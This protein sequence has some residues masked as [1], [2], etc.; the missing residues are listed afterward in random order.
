MTIGFWQRA[1]NPVEVYYI[2]D[3]KCSRYA[4]NVLKEL[5]I[6]GRDHTNRSIV[7]LTPGDL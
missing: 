4:R 6:S 3:T 2:A 7:T 5:E 1:E